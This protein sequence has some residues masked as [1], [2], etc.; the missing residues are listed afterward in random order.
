[1]A[2]KKITSR[3]V[4]FAQ[5]YT[6]VVTAARLAAYSNVKG[7]VIFEPNGYAIW[8]RIMHELDKKFKETGHQNVAMP[9]LIPENLMNKEGEL[10]NG[11]APEVAWVTMGGQKELEERL[12]I[13]PTS[14]TLFSD[15][16]SDVVK[17]YRDLPMKLNQ[18]CSVMRWEKETRP[19][20]RSREFFWQ[21]GHTVH[22]TSEE[23]E[24]ETK[25]M[26]NVYRKFFEDYLAVPV[27]T[28]LKTEKEKF[29]GAEYTYTVEA[30]MHNGVALQSGTSHYFGQK[31]A[32]A[33]D[34]KFLN[35]NN[36]LEYVYQT[37]W[38]VSNRMIG[39]LI[40]V[41]GDDNGLIL[42]PKI[43]P[44]Q[45]VIIP[46]GEDEKVT[47]T[48]NDIYNKLNNAGIS[49]Y[50]DNTE[51]SPGFKFAEAEVNGIPVRI[52]VGKRDLETNTI[53]VARRDTSQKSTIS[54][55]TD[56]VTY[57]NNL[58]S[59]IQKNLYN[60]ALARQNEL[61]FEAK[62]TKE[63]EKIM[64][65]HPGFIKAD[66]CGSLEC[67]M[68]MKEIKGT[69][70]RCILEHEKTLNGKCVVCGKEAKHLVVWG[71]QY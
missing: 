35:K 56:I 21:E 11:F 24:K 66:W 53:T 67:E 17:S 13:R 44:K 43:A 8:E 62:D 63:V 42:P 6:D 31:F 19:F 36:E 41:H 10:I 55:G 61:T 59:D 2:N 22:A 50:V 28:G 58:M 15:Y 14:E 40:M 57:V 60:R 9:M 25:D 4:D 33:Y 27:I 32:K 65:E 64:E 5:W 49:V 39:A 16:Y 30:L 69:K 71:I 38:G 1:M 48:V 23:A 7:C 46:I 26:L 70:S 54:V 12:C 29:A 34:I 51:K 3:D 20:L 68:Q 52:E 18:W 45:V 47:N 37:S